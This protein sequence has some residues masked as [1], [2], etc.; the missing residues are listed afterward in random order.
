MTSQRPTTTRDPR[1]SLGL[2]AD[3]IHLLE[4]HGFAL[5]E[6]PSSRNRAHADTLV[7]VHRL[8]RAFEGEGA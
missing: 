5:P 2:L 3:V 4:Q 7:A 1:M 8:A 6:E